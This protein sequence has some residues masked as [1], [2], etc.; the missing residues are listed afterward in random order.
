MLIALV[1]LVGAAVATKDSWIHKEAARINS[2]PEM[3]WTAKAYPRFAK[4]AS[5]EDLAK[6][7]ISWRASPEDVEKRNGALPRST[8]LLEKAKLPAAFD[9]RT[10][11]PGCVHPV[12]DQGQ[13]GS[14]WSFGASEALGDRFCVQSNGSINVALSPQTLI[15]CDNWLSFGCNGGMPL[16][17]WWYMERHG[18]VSLTCLPYLSGNGQVP[19]CM[20]KCVNSTETWKEYKVKMGS[21]QSHFGVESMQ[22]ALIK[23]GPFEV[24]F[25]VFEDFMSYSGGVYVRKSNSFQG[26]HAVKVVGWGHDQPS[27]LDYWIVQNSWGT[28]WGE[29][30][31]FRI[32]RGQNECFIETGGVSGDAAL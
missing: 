32:L 31:F 10:N 20:N 15:S 30:G 16:A 22:S 21:V 24:S 2:L 6:K 19:P 29:N 28:D 13:C 12:L 8:F 27:N 23:G 3:S 14:C 7:L 1:A 26:M 18:L 17:T 11:W 9:A 4:E 25:A 5:V